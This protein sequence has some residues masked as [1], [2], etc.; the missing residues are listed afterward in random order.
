M[1]M[2]TESKV[3]RLSLCDIF[4]PI[5]LIYGRATQRCLHSG[6]SPMKWKLFFLMQL[7]VAAADVAVAIE[8]LP[9]SQNGQ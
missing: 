7:D 5:E 9:A 1:E 8:P 3:E 4:V 6:S 2:E